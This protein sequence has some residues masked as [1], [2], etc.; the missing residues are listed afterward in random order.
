[1]PPLPIARAYRIA[2]AWQALAVAVIAATSGLFAGSHG[3]LS[4]LVGGGIGIVGLIAFALVSSRR[5][6]S[7]VDAIRIALRA[8]AVKV[9]AVVLLLW[10]S[11][12]AYRNLAVLP[13]IGAFMVSVMLSAIAFAVPDKSS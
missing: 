12:T 9:V 4:A 1:M 5:A 2:I 10:L 7:A 3:F 13:F 6:P 8:E 11:F